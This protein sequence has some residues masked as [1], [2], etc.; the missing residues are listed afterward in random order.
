MTNIFLP[1]ISI[2][3]PS[4]NQGKYIERTIQ[5]VI[6][7]KYENLEYIIIDGGSSDDSVKIIQLYESSLAYW[8]SER[9]SG[10]SNAINKGFSHATGTLFGWLNSDDCLTDGAL[11]NIA[12][13]FQQ[14]PQAGAF[15]GAGEYVDTKE[16]ILLRKEPSEVTFE[17]LYNWL[18]VFHFMQPS[19]F[20]SREAWN[21]AGGLDESL[22]YAM[23][24]DL[25]FKIAERFTFER[26]DKLFSRSLI[27]A[28]AKT[29]RNKYL[30]EVTAAFVI[31]KHGGNQQARLA[32]DNIAI[33]MDYF[34]YC[35]TFITESRVFNALLPKMKRIIR[36][37]KLFSKNSD[38]KN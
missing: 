35:I 15:V 37:D 24:L 17:S 33:K 38:S 1:K 4:F 3:T 21:C 12:E 23:D 8:V 34:E 11:H 26:S 36:Y 13:M 6:S 19:C 25:W 16:R 7:Q 31:M 18:E 14:N 32:L 2:V 27:H 20:F 5:S 29:K 9:D 30:S 10:Q 22:H 28:S